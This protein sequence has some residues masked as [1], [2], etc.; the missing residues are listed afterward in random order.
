MNKLPLT[1]VL[2]TG[3]RNYADKLTVFDCLVKLNEQFERLI[4]VH[5]DADGA[6]TL[7]YEVCKEVG[8]EQA[9]VPATWN[10]YLKAAGPIRNK[11]MLDLFPVDL[12][13]AFAGDIGTAD[14]KKQATKLGIPVM[15]PEDLLQG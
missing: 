12:I 1:F 3:G 8:I 4:V 13:M 11:L 10:K 2:V 15:T 5:G 6:D 9:R 14:M 7:A